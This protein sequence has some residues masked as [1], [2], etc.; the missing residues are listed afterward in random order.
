M[1]S[2]KR[3]EEGVEK[4]RKRWTTAEKL[5]IVRTGMKPGVEITDLCH[6]EGVNPTMY[7]QWKRQLLGA[8]KRIFERREHKPS[9]REQRLSVELTWAKNVIAANTAE[10]LDLKKTFSGQRN[11][12][13]EQTKVPSGWPA[14][15]TLSTLGIPP[16]RSFIVHNRDGE[17]DSFAIP[18]AVAQFTL[19]AAF[20]HLLSQTS[21]GSARRQGAMGSVCRK[22]LSG[23]TRSRFPG[24]DTSSLVDRSGRAGDPAARRPWHRWNR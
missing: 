8:A 23:T 16:R 7:Y 4:K 6:P 3:I 21:L 20:D 13:V 24:I 15:R 11:A 9:A 1:K 12:T 5:E 2:A 17:A 10:N 14:R 22:S 19:T 18:F